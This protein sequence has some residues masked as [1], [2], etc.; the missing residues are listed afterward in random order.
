MNGVMQQLAGQA[1][2]VMEPGIGASA[3]LLFH[4]VL[5]GAYLMALTWW[6]SSRIDGIDDD[7]EHVIRAS[8]VMFVTIG[9]AAVMILVNNSLA[10]AFAVGAAIALV[11]FRVK[12]EGKFIGMALLYGVI[13]GMACGVD[14]LDVAWALSAIFGAMLGAVL[15]LRK[16]SL[17]KPRSYPRTIVREEAAPVPSLV[18]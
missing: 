1:A 17:K 7:A 11:R 6:V 16:F 10:R 18:D 4:A 2:N 13:T 5:V 9:V 8:S 14:R 15:V 3:W 12:M